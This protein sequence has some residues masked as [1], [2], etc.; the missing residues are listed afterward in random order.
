MDLAHKATIVGNTNPF[1]SRTLSAGGKGSGVIAP[2]PSE[3][4]PDSFVLS[5]LLSLSY[6][7]S[8]LLLSSIGISDWVAF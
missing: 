6:V 4:N 7:L 3:N 2:L 8:S 5:L 1:G